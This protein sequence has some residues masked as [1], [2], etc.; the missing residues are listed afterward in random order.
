VKELYAEL[1]FP[2]LADRPFVHKLEVD[3]GF[4]IRT[5]ICL[6]GRIL[7]RPT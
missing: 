1:L 7:G 2:L 5:T 3:A 6:A 4:A